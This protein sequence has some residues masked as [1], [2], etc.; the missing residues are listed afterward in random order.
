MP[1]EL[2]EERARWMLWELWNLDD[3]DGLR[4][5]LQTQLEE[6]FQGPAEKVT[7]EL[8]DLAD[9]LSVEQATEEDRQAFRRLADE[10]ADA[11]DRVEE[12]IERAGDAF[13]DLMD[14]IRSDHLFR[15]WAE[16]HG[17]TLVDHLAD[18]EG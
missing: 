14:G 9:N 1:D 10:L 16:R 4:E 6:R 17:I 13:K 5:A 3:V 8:L 11:C 12:V 2:N 18:P 7:D 15:Q